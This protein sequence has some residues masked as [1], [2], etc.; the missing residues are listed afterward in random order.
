M[1]PLPHWYRA[2]YLR[3]ATRAYDGVTL[4]A[5]LGQINHNS[6]GCPKHSPRCGSGNVMRDATGGCDCVHSCRR[7]RA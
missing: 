7:R 5:D 1:Q 3:G 2:G 6:T 4:F